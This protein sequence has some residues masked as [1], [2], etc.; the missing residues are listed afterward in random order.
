[1]SF[2][3][4]ILLVVALL[5][6]GCSTASKNQKHGNFDK[7]YQDRWK[8]AFL[9]EKTDNRSEFI[10][11]FLKGELALNQEDFETASLNL[12]R[13]AEISEGDD[14]VLRQQLVQLL[15]EKGDL[16]TA[17][18]ENTK[19]IEEDPEYSD[20]VL[21][22]GILDTLGQNE[23]AKKIYEK[24]VKLNSKDVA[25]LLFL[26]QVNYALN[27]IDA[28]ITDIEKVVKLYPAVAIGHFYLGTLAQA[29]GDL[30]RA[31]KEFEKAR[32]LENDNKKIQLSYVRALLE[33]GFTKEATKVLTE[34]L[35]RW[36][37]SSFV[38]L[39]RATDSLIKS[40]QEDKAKEFLISF[41]GAEA[42]EL[43]E[44]R[45]HVGITY[46]E[47]RD[48]VSAIQNFRLLLA[49]N[50][51]DARARY[52]LGTAYAALGLKI[53]AV[54]ELRSVP[55]SDTMFVEAQ[56]FASFLLRQIG[57][58]AEAEESIKDALSEVEGG[59]VN[60][61]LFLVDIL[62]AE[63]KYSEAEDIAE[64]ILARNRKD[65]KSLFLYGS[66]L[67]ERG[68]KDRAIEVM[69]ELLAINPKHSQALNFVAYSLA[70]ESRD[71]D[72][73]LELSLQALVE[74]P[75]DGYFLDT[76]GWV[77]FLRGEKAKAVTVLSRA[78]NLTGDDIVILEHY[79]DALLGVGRNEKALD[80]YI[81][82]VQKNET[83]K[84]KKDVAARSRCREKISN[85]LESNPELKKVAV[86]S[87]YK[88]KQ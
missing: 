13:A 61:E 41:L 54:A 26:A 45:R 46:V 72:R 56:T 2:K 22:G 83:V 86:A 18:F 63:Q 43:N 75:D 5:S 88:V 58:L 3:S 7:E 15:I 36:E 69:S 81:T 73:A 52:F 21:Q 64:K 74:Y 1:M 59:D 60:L 19:L 85:L 38:L 32:K 25:A 51:E 76:L 80:I 11:H 87:G 17:L 20:L 55:P 67:D 68:K 79:G 40:G 10:F 62:R 37:Q 4:S 39:L 71:L 35:E 78:V 8:Q 16:E 53:R 9:D 84:N 27:N 66:I 23:E 28:A 44:L 31:L 14:A 47:Q 70:E 42:I 65:E 57:K 50:P 49:K 77:R 48:F 12:M 30:K 33:V 34:L 24:C 6:V 82:A 29:N